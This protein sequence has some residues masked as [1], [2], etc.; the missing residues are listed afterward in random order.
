MLI[1]QTILLFG[2]HQHTLTFPHVTN[3]IET[4][5]DEKVKN[6]ET[7]KMNFSKLNGCFRKKI[8][9]HRHHFPKG[10]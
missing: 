10:F 3:F 7:G 9:F 4:K 5:Q 1:P 8:P 6:N 2:S